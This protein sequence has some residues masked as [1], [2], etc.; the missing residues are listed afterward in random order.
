MRNFICKLLGALQMLGGILGLLLVILKSAND[1]L[2]HVQK[3]GLAHTSSLQY[4]L[5]PFLFLILYS[6]AIRAGLAL[7]RDLPLGYRHSTFLQALQ[8]PVIVTHS[9]SYSFFITM[10]LSI[11]FYK[12]A[13]QFIFNHQTIL[14]STYLLRLS[15]PQPETLQAF[16]INVVAIGFLVLLKVCQ[17]L[18]QEDPLG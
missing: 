17:K 14:N 5:F 12:P 11:G 3:N 18:P 9:V 13:H 15:P 10:G 2:V 1:L 6:T 16:Y 4:I 8:I 7:Y